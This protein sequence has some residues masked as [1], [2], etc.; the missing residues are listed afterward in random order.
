MLLS[1]LAFAVMSAFVKLAG[2]QGIP[3]LE[4]IAARAL[5]SLVIS[6]L[7]VRRKGIPVF[8]SHRLLLF[9]RGLVGFVSLTGVFYSLVHLSIA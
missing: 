8:G 5:V 1:A 7:D 2:Q 9:A 6:Y 3:V 4:I